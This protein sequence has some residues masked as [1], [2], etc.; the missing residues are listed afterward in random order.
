[1]L[2]RVKSPAHPHCGSLGV[3]AHFQVSSFIS[4]DLSKACCCSASSQQRCLEYGGE[5]LW[6]RLVIFCRLNE[7]TLE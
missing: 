6:A 1:M 5:Q 2:I 3:S 4:M 7:F